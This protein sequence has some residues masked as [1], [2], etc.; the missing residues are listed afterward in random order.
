MSPRG[1]D[2]YL[3]KRLASY[4]PFSL[5]LLVHEGRHTDI[6]QNR[7]IILLVDNMV[8]EHLVVQGLGLSISSRH[9]C[10]MTVQNWEAGMKK[11]ESQ[12]MDDEARL[13][14]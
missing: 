3:C 9:L 13:Y 5:P 2:V 8:V 10:C 6:Q 14:S 12:G 1:Q 7:A 4:S 11:K